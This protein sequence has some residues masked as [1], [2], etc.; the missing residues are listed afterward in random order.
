MNQSRTNNVTSQTLLIS[1]ESYRTKFYIKCTTKYHLRVF[2]GT[3][4]YLPWF[5]SGLMF[6]YALCS[7]L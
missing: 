6:A 1:K 3:T 7:L 4:W 5:R 2:I